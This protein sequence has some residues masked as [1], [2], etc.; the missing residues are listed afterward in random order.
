[1]MN[2]LLLRKTVSAFI[3]PPG[4]FILLIVTALFLFWRKRRKVAAAVLW[5]VILM[6]LVLSSFIG[7]YILLWPLEEGYAPAAGTKLAEMQEDGKKTAVVVLASGI[8]RKNDDDR[9]ESEIGE[10]TLKRLVGGFKV[11]KETGFP[12]CVSGGIE[13]GAQGDTLAGVMS[14]EL[15]AFGVP[16]S[17][18]I[19]EGDSRTTWENAVY[20]M[21]LLKSQ[22]FERVLL[23]T[24]AVHMKRSVEVFQ[25]RGL[26]VVPYPSGYLYGVPGLT[27][28]LPNSGSLNKNLRALH[29]WAGLV[30]YRIRY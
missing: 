17:K 1:M 25:N 20:S 8:T 24:D 23:V 16:K 13:P 22:G 14:K 26:E 28:W 12:I 6:I 10:A 4:L 21:K 2:L 18:I 3:V 11:Y 9:K 30:Y 29:E 19:E 5:L 15:I 27:D 7:E